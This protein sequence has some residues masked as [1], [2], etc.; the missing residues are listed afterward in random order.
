MF[1]PVVVTTTVLLWNTNTSTTMIGRV[2]LH[3]IF[4]WW[5]MILSHSSVPVIAFLIIPPIHLPHGIISNNHH[6]TMGYYGTTPTTT[7]IIIPTTTTTTTTTLTTMSVIPSPRMNP[8]PKKITNT[9]L[10]PLQSRMIRMDHIYQTFLFRQRQ[11]H[12]SLHLVIPLLL[13]STTSAFTTITNANTKNTNVT[14]N[15]T[16]YNNCNTYY[17][18][19]PIT[20]STATTTTT[21]T[22]TY[23]T[24]TTIAPNSDQIG[25]TSRNTIEV[26]RLPLRME[27]NT[28][29]RILLQ[30]ALN[31]MVQGT[32]YLESI[33]P[34]P[35][36]YQALGNNNNNNNTNEKNHNHSNHIHNNNNSHRNTWQWMCY[37]P[38]FQQY[39]YLQY[40][41]FNSHTHNN[42]SNDNY[43]DRTTISSSN[44]SQTIPH[45][46]YGYI[47]LSLQKQLPINHKSNECSW[48][49]YTNHNVDVDDNID[50]PNDDG[51]NDFG[52]ICLKFYEVYTTTAFVQIFDDTYELQPRV[53]LQHSNL[54]AIHTAWTTTNVTL[55]NDTTGNSSDEPTM[56]VSPRDIFIQHLSDQYTNIVPVEYRNSIDNIS[57]GTSTTGI[58][59]NNTDENV[60][61]TTKTQRINHIFR[62]LNTRGYIIIDPISDTDVG[63]TSS[64]PIHTD[65]N[66]NNDNH[67]ALLTTS[68]Q[69]EAISK[70][71]VPSTN[72]FTNNN[73]GVD[74]DEHRYANT[75]RTDQIHFLS[76]K[77]QARDGQIVSQYNLLMGLPHFMNE[78]ENDPTYYNTHNIGSLQQPQQQ[79]LSVPRSIQFA[80][81]GYGDFYIVCMKSF[82]FGFFI[83][84]YRYVICR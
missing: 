29:T 36:P 64:P 42:N 19:I 2:V 53:L 66:T 78:I 39:V 12:S 61:T 48:D 70:Y 38:A 30:R 44:K 8:T 4:F 71:F 28:T 56:Y 72:S 55:L 68:Q 57:T 34:I 80:E 9:L 7:N 13:T 41:R 6:N 82:C 50:I 59:N 47:E 23:Y 16:S 32:S 84:S 65:H 40:I 15:N 17:S 63:F 62:T 14:S 27:F 11:Q 75:I 35:H 43:T 37:V 26:V 83:C 76:T 54:P 31:D 73:D 1:R 52:W 5:N 3:C 69:Q 49:D 67:I 10:V 18:N 79:L 77:E 74:H 46:P 81:Y 25:N 33:L 58:G 20:A 45:F 21:T 60:E 51:N 24:T 22:S